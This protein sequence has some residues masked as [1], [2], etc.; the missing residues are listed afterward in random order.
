MLNNKRQEQR[1]FWIDCWFLLSVVVVSWS[2][3][4]NVGITHEYVLLHNLITLVILIGVRGYTIRRCGTC[5]WYWVRNLPFESEDDW[6]F[7]RRKAGCLHC[8]SVHESWL[9]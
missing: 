8:G 2:F 5:R 4:A 6:R 1:S 7:F 3:A 9:L